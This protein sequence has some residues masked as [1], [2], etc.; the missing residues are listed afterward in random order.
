MNDEKNEMKKI[1]ILDLVII[2]LERKWLF[3]I[4]LLLFSIAGLIASMTMTK[5]YAGKAIIMKPAS[6]MPGLGSLLG[7]ETQ[8]AGLLKSMD[9]MGETDADNFLSILR[10]RRLAEKVIDRF[11]LVHVYRFDKMKKYY[12]EDVLKA[13]SRNS[14]VVENEMGNI[15]VAVVDTS[16]G[17]AAAMANFMVDELDSIT[18]QLSKESARNSRI[19]FEERLGVIKHDLDSASRAFADFQI[20]NKYID[21][22]QQVKSSIEQVATFEGQKMGMDLEIAQLRSQFSGSNQRVLEL[23]KEKGVIEK[24]ISGYMDQGGGHLIVS[25]S[26]A[27]EKAIKYAE[28][29]GNA[30]LQESLYEFVIQLYEQAKISEAN[31]VPSIQVLE[32]AKVAQKKTRPKRSIVCLLFFFVGFIATS[33]YIL[34]GKW[35]K[36]QSQHRT[37]VYLKVSRIRTLLWSAKAPA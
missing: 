3:I 26:N 13:F 16:P 32:Y 31:N 1:G 14:A 12:I 21:L 24:K 29:K 25:L 8:V 22:E 27:P 9:G 5:Y 4:S 23:E 20:E 17:R 18:Y 37:A 15:E 11:D 28:L 33:T 6:K 34:M 10:S 19:F 7:K 36:A 30:K 2:L 35:W